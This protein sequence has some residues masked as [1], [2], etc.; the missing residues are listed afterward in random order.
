M[1]ISETLAP[2]SDQIDYEDLLGGPRTFT[3]KEVRRGPS[4]EQPVE[5]V[6]HEFPRPWRPAKTVRRILVACWGPDASLYTGRRVTLYADH[7]VKFG[8]SAVGGIRLSHASHIDGAVTV[9][10]M[11]TRGK[12]APF[13][14]QPLPD[15]DPHL[16]TLTNAGTLDALKTA[17][18]NLPATVRAR[19]DV[20]AAKNTRKTEL[21]GGHKPSD[22]EPRA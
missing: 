12:R 11:I 21:E 13:T 20:V 14:V 9:T 15:T 10:A 2:K 17:W 1:D 5:V 16:D 22:P 18:E 4:A 3:I 7:T 8:G 6:M 19:P